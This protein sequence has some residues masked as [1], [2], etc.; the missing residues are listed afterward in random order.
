MRK[1]LDFYGYNSPS[2][3]EY[4]ADGEVYTLGED[5]RS[6]KRYKE[7]KNVGFN[8]LLLQHKNTFSGEDFSLSACKKC[9]DEGYKAGLDRI[10]VSDSRLKDL[11]V[12]KKLVG[13]GGKFA[14]EREFYDYLDFCTKPY[15]NYPGFYGVQLYDEP[16]HEKIDATAEVYAALKKLFPKMKMQVNLMN[17]CVPRFLTPTPGDVREDYANYLRRFADNSGINYLMTDEY[18]F[19]RNNV[20]SNYTVPTFQVLANVCKEKNLEFRMVLQS[21]SQQ[22]SAVDGDVMEGGIAWRRVTE[23]DMYWQMNLAMG[24][25]CKEYSFFTYMT[26]PF[27]SFKGKRAVTDGVDGAAFINYDGSRTKLYG[28]TKRIISEVKAF[29]NVLL[30]YAYNDS[31]F[32]FEDGKSYKDFEQTENALISEKK[33][34]L[35]VKISK[36]VAL[37]T[38][39]KGKNKAKLYMVENIRNTVEQFMHKEKP[40][41]VVIDLGEKAESATFYFRGKPVDKKVTDGKVKLKMNCGDA[42]FIEIK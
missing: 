33:C 17:M 24:F 18:A 3:G 6:V 8:I 35:S 22:G 5:Y 42:L 37:V 4:Y 2:N 21:F 39:S 20:I 1:H 38:E 29:E 36:G 26:K 30:S 23:K 28:Y 10:I 15:R 13:E 7:Y 12:E 14:T 19:R 9:M 27:L 31:F 11:C 16:T 25:G 32:F 40:S 41:D 34:P